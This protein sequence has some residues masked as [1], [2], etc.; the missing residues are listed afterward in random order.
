M[1]TPQPTLR[2]ED[3][4]FLTGA[5]RY[6]PNHTLPGAL[7]VIFVRSVMAHARLTGIATAEAARQ[8]GVIRVVTGADLDLAPVM[9]DMAGLGVNPLMTRPWLATDVV[10]YVGE[11]IAAVIA[12]T[13]EQAFDAAEFVEVSYDPLP[14]VTD[15]R[16]ARRDEVLLF[17]DAGT[18]VAYELGD[19]PTE[20]FFDGCEV[21][22]SHSIHNQ[23]VAPCPLEV[24]SA[25]AVWEE[26]R[27]TFW[28]GSQTPHAVRDQIA[29]LYDLDPT[30]V[31]VITPDVGGGFGAK[32]GVG[33]DE[34]LLVHLARLT[35]SPVVFT[36]TRSESMVATTHGRAQWQEIEIGGT[37]DGRIQAY[38]LQVL[39]DAGAYPRLGAILPTFTSLMAQGV[40]DIDRVETIPVSLVTNTTPTG[41]YR[42]AGRP[43]ATAA[44]ERAVDL[45]AARI[46]MDPVEV[47]RRNLIASDAFPYSTATDA[48][49]D[50]GDYA[51]ALDTLLKEIDYAGLRSAQEEQR[52]QNHA[53]AL[54]IGISVYVEVTAPLIDAE[55]ATID[56][57]ED[58]RA[59]VAVGT[60][61]HG[62]GHETVFAAMAA[63]RLG[64][65]IDDI[66]FVA[67]D[68]DRVGSGQGTMGSRSLQTGGLAVV[69]ACDQVVELAR[70][71]AADHFEASS[72]DVVFD[73]ERGRFFVTGTPA[74]ALGWAELVGSAGEVRVGVDAA[75]DPAGSTFPFG[76][77]AAI[78]EIDTET[79]Y[80]RLLRMVAVDDAGTVINPTL[81]EGQ[82]HGGLAQGIAQAL[83]E[84]FT[85]D[86]SGNPL[87]STFADYGI[88]SAA[89]LPSFETFTTETPTPLNELGVKGI[90]E[91]GT[92]GSTA[93]V[94]SA[95][96]DALGPFGVEHLDMPLTPERV[97]RAMDESKK[98]HH[99]KGDR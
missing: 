73:I 78:V 50:S 77:H 96:I 6:L 81:A 43:E 69:T 74:L 1:S 34:L 22:V 52:R 38:R 35:D 49:Y 18:N 4:R 9:P 42:G 76:A 32:I 61:S 27:V 65:G 15:V 29:L 26:D 82:I 5:G 60:M 13:P 94:Q 84:E 80:I 53:V 24:R 44:I 48:T 30:L 91:S 10:R 2:R 21:V 25:A 28:S 99:H 90:G 93:A 46:G 47:R 36:E 95:V 23:R 98:R 20:G 8:P 39:G 79:G 59:T 33:T 83:Y 66:E 71:L 17:P 87:T 37:R 57:G 75:F 55:E 45:F 11:P 40:Y 41:A 16:K 62:Q 31:R 51:G 67:G 89:E 70:R 88:P 72:D 85:Y 64:I 12:Q 86:Q 97:W 56:I 3:R 68:T 63:D 54:G 19:V 14:V 58:G 7:S 92:I